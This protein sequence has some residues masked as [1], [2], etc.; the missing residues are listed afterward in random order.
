MSTFL[1]GHYKK[2]FYLD[3]YYTLR[4][5]VVVWRPWSVF[6]V[7]S[8]LSECKRK[9]F[10][11]KK[12]FSEPHGT[13]SHGPRWKLSTSFVAFRWVFALGQ[14]F[15]CIVYVWMLFL[16]SVQKIIFCIYCGLFLPSRD[17]LAQSQQWAQENNWNLFKANNKDT[18]KMTLMSFGVYY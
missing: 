4:K 3:K 9:G 8:E 2:L 6:F 18:T 10:P 7:R 17:L 14:S 12:G 15:L 11:P 16:V 1:L 13:Q 5:K